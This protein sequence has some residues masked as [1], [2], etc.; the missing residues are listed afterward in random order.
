MTNDFIDKW[1]QDNCQIVSGCCSAQGSMAYN[2][3]REVAE[4]M[5]EYILEKTCE[6][7][8][9]YLSYP[10]DTDFEKERI[11]E[12]ISDFRKAMEE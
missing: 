3:G 6:W 9:E 5:R 4:K 7:W 2:V 8:A 12:M 1:L 10:T 11:N